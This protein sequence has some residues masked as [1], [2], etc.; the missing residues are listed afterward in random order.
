MFRYSHRQWMRWPAVLGAMLAGVTSF[1]SITAAQ[2]PVALAFV[3]HAAFFSQEAHQPKALDPQVFVRDSSAK[4]A[5]GPQNIDHVEGYRNA[6]LTDPTD[7]PMFTARGKPLVGFTLGSWL[8][9]R[10]EVTITPLKSGRAKI[11]AKFTG[12]RPH[13][14][15]S[16]FENHFDQKP[17]GFTPLDG[18]GTKN[19]FVAKVNGTAAI[20]VI[21]PAMLTNANAILVVYHSDGKTHGTSRGVIGVTAQHQ[22]I[23]RPG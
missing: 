4:A 13:G 9:A 14:V 21:A 18:K 5:M 7:S 23:A 16:L 17:I 2:Q 15:Y 10:G 6:L 12:L 8:G 1:A 19:S 3:T 11:V 20:T 22:L